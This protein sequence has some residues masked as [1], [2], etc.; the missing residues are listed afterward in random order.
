MPLP[1]V[2]YQQ[3][4]SRADLETLRDAWLAEP[5]PRETPDPVQAIIDL[6]NDHRHLADLATPSQWHT[7]A[8]SA[9]P[10]DLV[11]SGDYD[12]PQLR[13]MRQPLLGWL[14]QQAT[15]LASNPSW[16]DAADQ[17]T[18]RWTTIKQAAETRHAQLKPNR[19]TSGTRIDPRREPPSLGPSGPDLTPG[20]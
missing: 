19:P 1:G 3:T 16:H 8:D 12:R 4:Y 11:S 18:S 17:L 2:E 15:R 9:S 13:G 6:V 7:L 10:D 20:W 14:D 5:Q